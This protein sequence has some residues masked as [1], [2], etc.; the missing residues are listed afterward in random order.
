MMSW[1][2]PI[3]APVDE[4]LP[5]AVAGALAI[6]DQNWLSDYSEGSD[7]SEFVGTDLVCGLHEED[8]KAASGAA[9]SS[10]SA[11][12]AVVAVDDASDANSEAEAEEVV[13]P[14]PP[15]P[16]DVMTLFRGPDRNGYITCVA[17]GRNAGRVSG[18]YGPNVGIKCF[19]EHGGS[20]SIP[21]AE[22]KVPCRRD[23]FAWL[24]A[25]EPVDPRADGVV[26]KAA[27]G[28]HIAELK[29]LTA[30]ST[31]PG[32]TRQSLVDEA[33]AAGGAV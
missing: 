21:L 20:C 1:K 31:W 9:A 11:P 7:K 13:P 2:G 28:R 29:K 26:K 6:D 4:P 10:S 22:W 19:Q 25:A 27:A 24:A 8:D 12:P 33:A 18:P 30:T 14:P 5:A 32:R 3:A 16:P 23:L 17:T 15:P